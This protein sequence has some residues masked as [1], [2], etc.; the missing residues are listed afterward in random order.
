MDPCIWRSALLF[1][2]MVACTWHLGSEQLFVH[3][4]MLQFAGVHCRLCM[5]ACPWHS[6]LQFVHSSMHPTPV[7]NQ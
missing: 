1:V 6:A 2:H 5:M 7:E 3:G 4:V